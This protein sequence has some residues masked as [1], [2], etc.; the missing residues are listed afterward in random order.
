MN[1]I[2]E[3]KVRKYLQYDLLYDPY[4]VGTIVYNLVELARV[5]GHELDHRFAGA[6]LGAGPECRVASGIV[7]LALG[8]GGCET[9]MYAI[10]KEIEYWLIKTPP[11]GMIA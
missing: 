8:G 4:Q 2:D 7:N 9:S 6:G 10:R 5:A 3:F 1:S 11:K